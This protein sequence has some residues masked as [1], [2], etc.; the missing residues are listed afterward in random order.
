MLTMLGKYPRHHGG[1]GDCAGADGRTDQERTSGFIG[2]AH[3]R[4]LPAVLSECMP[5]PLLSRR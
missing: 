2:L 3:D 1:P 4:L 5:H